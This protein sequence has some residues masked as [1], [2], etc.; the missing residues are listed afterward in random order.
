VGGLAVE[1]AVFLNTL[2]EGAGAASTF[3]CPGNKDK[4][5]Q[6]EQTF[7]GKRAKESL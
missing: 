6:L 2:Q 4:G 3:P 1:G 5:W 7:E